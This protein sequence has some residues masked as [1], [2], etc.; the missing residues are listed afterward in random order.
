MLSLIKG[1]G[2]L[3]TIPDYRIL[4]DTTD[5]IDQFN[6]VGFHDICL[7]LNLDD[8]H[9]YLQGVKSGKKGRDVVFPGYSETNST[10]L[11]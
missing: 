7:M 5:L 3:K 2:L 1:P 4:R 11:D 8:R 9:K 6:Y 10:G